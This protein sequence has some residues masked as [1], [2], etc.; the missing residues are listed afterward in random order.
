V[1]SV[2]LYLLHFPS[3]DVISDVIMSDGDCTPGRE[4]RSVAASCLFFFVT[5]ISREALY[6]FAPN[7]YGRRVWSL[8]RTSLNVKVTRDKTV[9]T[10]ESS[11]LTMHCNACAVRSEGAAA[12]G[13]ISSPAG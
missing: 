5:Q 3:Y 6:G 12:D 7:S 9:K 10:A 1:V 11:P 4:P 2:F 13:T 8:A